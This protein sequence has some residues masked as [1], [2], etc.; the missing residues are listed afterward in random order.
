[1]TAWCWTLRRAEVDAEVW[2]LH[3]SKQVLVTDLPG[4]PG[5]VITSSDGTIGGT[6]FPSDVFLGHFPLPIGGWGA[7]G[8]VAQR[9]AAE[10]GYT[11]RYYSMQEAQEATWDDDDGDSEE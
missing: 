3:P 7:A 6:Y 1:V 4:P 11:V 10:L 8:E 2:V 5:E 9:K